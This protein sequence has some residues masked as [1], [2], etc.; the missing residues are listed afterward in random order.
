MGVSEIVCYKVVDDMVAQSSHAEFV[1]L[2]LL[3]AEKNLEQTG[4]KLK[5]FLFLKR[6][7][8]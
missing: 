2:F 3:G 8:I 1:I 7:R 6:I 5:R 4:K